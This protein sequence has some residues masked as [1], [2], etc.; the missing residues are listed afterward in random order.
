VSVSNAILSRAAKLAKPEAVWTM[1]GQALTAL[2]TL[3]GVRVVTELVSP[4]V[5]GA[6]ALFL[7]VSNLLVTTVFVS[8]AQGAMHLYPVHRASNSLHLLRMSYLQAL[9]RSAT[10]ALLALIPLAVLG[11]WFGEISVPTIAVLSCVVL[12]DG[13]RNSQQ[14]L[15]TSNLRFK[16]YARPRFVSCSVPALSEYWPPMR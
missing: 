3:V 5:F 15:L 7:G 9:R 4:S 13:I 12:A 2:G 10:W 16:R 11:Y 14:G 6:V 8:V 1:G